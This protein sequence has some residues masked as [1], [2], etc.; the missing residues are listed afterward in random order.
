MRRALEHYYL[1][2]GADDPIIITIP[3]GAYVPAF[4]LHD[5]GSGCGEEESGKPSVVS[6][7]PR[8]SR[9]LGW[10]PLLAVILVGAGLI[11]G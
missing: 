6:E 4:T 1:T 7:Q 5:T 3:K 8:R 2:A 11:A 10:P 9:R